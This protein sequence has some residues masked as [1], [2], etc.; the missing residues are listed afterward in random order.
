[1]FR[2]FYVIIREYYIC[3]SLSY[4]IFHIAVVEIIA[5]QVILAEILGGRC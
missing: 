5:G 1:M 4:K 2:H 3:A